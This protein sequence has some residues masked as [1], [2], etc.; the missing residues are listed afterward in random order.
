MPQL[1]YIDDAGRLQTANLASE[2]FLIGR[3]MTCHLV[4]DDELMSREHVRIDREADG[5]YRVR[6]LGSR[7]KSYVNGQVITETLLNHGDIVRAGGRVFEYVAD[8]GPGEKVTLEFLTPDRTDPPNCEWIKVK[9]P[10]TLSTGQLEQ[11]S[12]LAG[13]PGMTSRPVDIADAALAQLLLDLQADRGFVALRGEAKME[14]HPIAQRGLR[15]PTGGA[16][17][18]VS[19][20]FVFNA[21]LQSVAGRYPQTGGQLD[22]KSGYAAS[23]LVAPLVAQGNVIGLIYVDRPVARKPFPS[24]ALQHMAAAGAQ[25][26]AMLSDASRRL[27]QSA[28][29]EGAAWLA[30]L[31]HVQRV[32]LPRVSSSDTFDVALK[33]AS[34]QVRCGDLCD[35]VHVDEHRCGVVII[36]GGGHGISGLAQASAIRMGLRTALATSDEAVVDPAPVL[37]A[38]SRSIAESPGRQVVPCCFVGIDLSLGKLSYV[39]AG[40]MPPLLMVAPGRLVTLD[41]PSLVLGVDADYHYESTRVDLPEVF[42]LVCHSDGLVEATNASGE[43]L[44]DQHLHETL[45]DREAFSSPEGIVAAVSDTLNSHLADGDPADDATVLVVGRG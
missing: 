2:S 30:T 26:G 9:A 35:V 1:R 12:R 36:D 4:F 5:R 23:A 11:L 25:L 6:D 32:L 39:N 43:A 28:A 18:P 7:N 17:M 15:R 8:G 13:T 29:I 41:Q 21:V 34:G 42:R 45:L 22:P 33:F 19:Q 40:G 37:S 20:A 38:L 27:A 44:G 16:L 3:A 31:R 24:A 14:L 10:L